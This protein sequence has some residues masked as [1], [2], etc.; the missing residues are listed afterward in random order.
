MASGTNHL[1]DTK[2]KNAPAGE[3]Y[4]GQGLMLRVSPKKKK[5]WVYRYDEKEGDKR[6]RQKLTLGVYDD[7]SLAEAREH[8]STCASILARGGNPK[9]DWQRIK[10]ETKVS[11]EEVTPLTFGQFVT[12]QLPRVTAEFE[13]PKHRQQWY[14]T[15]RTYCS[16]KPIW[17][18]PLTDIDQNDVGDCIKPIW[19]SKRETA[20]RLRGRIQTMIAIAK[21]L[22][23]FKGDNPAAWELQRYIV[24]EL[25][26]SE[27]KEK[28]HAA[29]DY[30]RIPE[31][32]A[33]LSAREVGPARDCLMMVILT[34]LRPSE[35]RE[36]KWDEIDLENREW[37]IPAARMKLRKAHTIPITSNMLEILLRQ[38]SRE[39]YIF[40]N[41]VKQNV[42]SNM[43]M[44]SLI[45]R[46]G[47]QAINNNGEKITV[48]GARSTFTDWLGDCTSFDEN[49]A[50]H[51][52]A[53]AVVGAKGHYRRRTS[54]EKRREVMQVYSDYVSGKLEMKA[55]PSNVISM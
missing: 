43:G 34:A 8:R 24:P 22:G 42:L 50:E 19:R 37:N 6:K 1:T 16:E 18:K 4:D 3:Y 55:L 5:V 17:T 46:M 51:Q 26:K 7:M 38:P 2:I 39:G 44:L 40:R 28:N 14:S 30:E 54:L 13:N 21:A 25:T 36:G 23:Y 45:R 9:T 12:D 20:S 15:F 33:N 48:H 31:F 32:W 27:R 41:P 52:Q 35:V 49:L 11:S 29:M 53:R 10:D 47:S